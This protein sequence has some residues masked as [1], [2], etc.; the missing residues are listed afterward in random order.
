METR[1]FIAQLLPLLLFYLFFAAPQDL[2]MFSLTPLGRFVAI[3]IVVFYTSVHTLYGVV[4]CV[5]IILYYQTD[6]VEGMT[7]IVPGMSCQIHTPV[8][9]TSIYDDQMGVSLDRST[10]Y[11]PYSLSRP[12]A[13]RPAQKRKTADE[14]WDIFDWI[15]PSPNEE[16]A[17]L[18][19]TTVDNDT[20]EGFVASMESATMQVAATTTAQK[21]ATQE[22]LVFPKQSDD[23]I[24]R[25]W[26]TWFSDD[27]SQPYPK[28]VANT[29]AQFN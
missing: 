11:I 2:L 19:E 18:Q 8:E 26:Q 21:L 1:I 15:S 5:A 29:A 3:L 17:A 24:F 16:A 25:T 12:T 20:Y 28:A 10:I 7:T 22:E 6:M 23:W 9:T 4:V 13:E 14:G 27:H